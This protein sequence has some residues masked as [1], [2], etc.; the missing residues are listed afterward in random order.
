M[1][2]YSLVSAQFLEFLT[3]P[4]YEGDYYSNISFIGVVILLVVVVVIGVVALG[5]LDV[6]CKLV[7][8]LVEGPIG[9]WHASNAVL[10]CC[11]SCSSLSCEDETTSA[12]GAN[13]LKTFCFAVMWWLLS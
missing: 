3:C 10:I 9:N 11:S 4:W 5:W 2:L 13:V 7:V 6:V 12:L 8:P 1:H